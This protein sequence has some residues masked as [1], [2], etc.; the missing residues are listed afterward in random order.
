MATGRTLDK[1]T[2]VYVDGYDMSGYGRTIGPVGIAYD[3][4][5][6]TAD[7]GDT[8][9]GYLRGHSQV[10]IGALN[11][12]YDNV[13]T[14]GPHAVF[15][16][17]ANGT[18]RTVLVAYGIRAAPA[19]GDQSFGGQFLQKAYQTVGEGAVTTTVPFSGWA[20]DA[21]SLLYGNGWGLLLHASGAET[22]ANTGT[23]FDCYQADQTLTGGFFIYHVL[24]GNGTAT[25]S[26]DDSANNSAFTA[27]SGATSGSINC[28]V[29]QHGIVAL[30][31]SATVRR[32]LRWQLAL[33]TA[34]TVTFVSAFMRG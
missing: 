9:K 2:R 19:A 16:G 17:T 33:G 4:H 25:I 10:D 26:C 3:E 24:A 14:V 34:T 6:L 8:V 21:T 23:G 20:T 28:A 7:M 29:V 31:N 22:A 11:G 32:Y 30:G 5:D 12:V 27:L 18:K 13:A 1:C 15:G